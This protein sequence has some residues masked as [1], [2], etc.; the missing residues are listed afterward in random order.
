MPTAQMYGDIVTMTVTI[1][2]NLTDKE[3][4]LVNLESTG[5]KIV[6]LAAGATAFPFVLAEGGDG[7]TTPLKGSIVL[8]GR[9]K[10]KL[11]GTVA[12]GDKLTSDG[13]GKAVTTVTDH[14]HYGFIALEDGVSGDIIDA[15]VS[16][17][18]VSA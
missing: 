17:G 11:G 10:V 16:L 4:Y 3:Y 5:E 15:L 7:S 12:A 14:N 6:N 2:T 1:D 13:N 18:T 9:V 8:S